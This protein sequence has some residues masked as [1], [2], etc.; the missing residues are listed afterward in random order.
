MVDRPDR[1][2]LHIGLIAFP[3]L[4]QLDLTGPYETL[5]RLPRSRVYIV[6]KSTAAIESDTALMIVP[7]MSVRG[8]PTAR[9]N[10][11]S[12]WSRCQ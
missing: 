5:A 7:S 11:R 3:R 1:P 2:E 8:M 4:T 10:L 12:W 9:R 6:A